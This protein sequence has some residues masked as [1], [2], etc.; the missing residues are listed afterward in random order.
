MADER[1]DPV[2][3]AGAWGHT[4]EDLPAGNPASADSTIDETPNESQ[5]SASH[6]VLHLFD[7]TWTGTSGITEPNS[8]LSS[9]ES[10]ADP[11]P[12]PARSLCVGRFSIESVLGIGGFG[13]VY[14]ATD[15][16]LGRQVALKVP[17]PHILADPELHQRFLIEARAAAGLEHPHI[18]PVYEAGE[19]G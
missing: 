6:D 17:Q 10:R 15:P 3:S 11:A 18:V 1:P 16:V 8:V 4:D 5:L 12:A 19:S 13:V 2:E 14:L 7:Q 9:G